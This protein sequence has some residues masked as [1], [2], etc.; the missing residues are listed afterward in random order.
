MLLGGK[1]YDGVKENLK[2]SGLNIDNL[3]GIKIVPYIYEL[4]E[5]MEASEA[6]VSRAG[7]STIAEIASA[8]KTIYSYSSSKCIS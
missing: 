7:A 4:Q 5:V 1:Q 8:R 3:D 6:L 2:A